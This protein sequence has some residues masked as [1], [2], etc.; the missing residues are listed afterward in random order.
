MYALTTFTVT[1]RGCRS[2]EANGVPFDLNDYSRQVDIGFAKVKNPA[3]WKGVE[4]KDSMDPKNF[5]IIKGGKKEVSAYALRD[6]HVE[7]QNFAAG[8]Y[9]MYIE[10]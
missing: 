1:Q 10:V 6:T 8:T 5:E 2:E 9:L 7:F 3:T 4:D